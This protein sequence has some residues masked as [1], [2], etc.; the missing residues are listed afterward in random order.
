MTL[1]TVEA[2]HDA[3]VI[4]NAG[5]AIVAAATAEGFEPVVAHVVAR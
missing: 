5:V 2:N 1:E 3:A 4:N